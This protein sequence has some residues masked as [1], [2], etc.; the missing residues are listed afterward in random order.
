MEEKDGKNRNE[1]DTLHTRAELH[2]VAKV[3]KYSVLALEKLEELCKTAE[4]DK[5]VEF[6]DFGETKQGV[7]AHT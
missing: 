5:F 1:D 3:R 7:S 2:R 6:A 4:P